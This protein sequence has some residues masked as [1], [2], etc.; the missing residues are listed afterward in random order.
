MCAVSDLPAVPPP[1]RDRL[2]KEGQPGGE[3]EK[4]EARMAAPRAVPLSRAPGVRRGA[5]AW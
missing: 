2:R 3:E 4:G 1:A 5:R